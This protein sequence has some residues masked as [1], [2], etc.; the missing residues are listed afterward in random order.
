MVYNTICCAR[1]CVTRGSGGTGRRA[2]LRGV[3]F[4]PYGFKSRFPHQ[5]KTHFCLVTK[6]RFLNDVCL[7]QMMLASPNDVRYA[8]DVCLRAHR[9][10]YRIIAERS[11]ATS[12]LR[13]KC[14]ISPQGDAS[15]KNT[16]A[17]IYLPKCDII[18]S[19][20]IGIRRRTIAR[21]KE[22]VWVLYVE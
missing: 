1:Q 2:R 20:I 9:G 13:S 18:N 14:I 17:L 3:W 19:L 5:Q 7:R 15:F 21:T 4:T 10:K 8:N 12:Y 6:V 16:Y 22:G 11:G